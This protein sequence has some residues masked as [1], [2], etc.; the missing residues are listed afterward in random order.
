MGRRLV[1]AAEK[2]Y[3]YEADD[4]T[5]DD[6]LSALRVG[7]PSGEQGKALTFIARL[8]SNNEIRMEDLPRTREEIGE[9]YASVPKLRAAGKSI[10][11]T[12][13]GSRAK[14]LS[15]VEEVVP[16]QVEPSKRQA[17]KQGKQEGTDVVLKGP[18]MTILR[19]KTEEAACFYGA[20]TKWCTAGEK[21]NRFDQYAKKG[22]LYVIMTPTRKFQLSVEGDQFMDERDAAVGPADIKMLSASQTYT[23]FL[24]M[25]IEKHYGQHFEQ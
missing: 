11:L 16:Q 5:A 4:P 17:T 21:D 10:D 12:S 9:F 20:G 7:D 2:D 15:A 23:K 14:M 13:Y 22:P 8:Y 3:S 19:L 25:L 24:N 18:D 1:D 6:V